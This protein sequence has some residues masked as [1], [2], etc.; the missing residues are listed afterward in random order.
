VALFIFS[1]F[2]FVRNDPD[3]LSS[4][5]KGN[6]SIRGQLIC[7]LARSGGRAAHGNKFLPAKEPHDQSCKQQQFLRT[8]VIMLHDSSKFE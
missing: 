1:N 8:R 5:Q 4:T 7:S 2:P 3:E 6:I